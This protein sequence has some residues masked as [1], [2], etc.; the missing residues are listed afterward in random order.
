M[1]ILVALTVGIAISI[2][3]AAYRYMRKALPKNIEN[4][5][6]E[7]IWMSVYPGPRRMK[8]RR[9]PASYYHE[10]DRR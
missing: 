4:S 10:S 2:L 1:T 8:P 9:P 3:L 6:D 7:E 5:S